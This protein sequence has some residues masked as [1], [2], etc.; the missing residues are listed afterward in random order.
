[1]NVLTGH[2]NVPLW[3]FLIRAIII[4]FALLIA[5]RIT[6][7]EQI[8]SL[9]PYDFMISITFG[10]LAAHPL[11]DPRFGVGPTVVSMA[12]L[13]FLNV[14]ISV[15]TLK[16]RGFSHVVGGRPIVLVDHGKPVK[17][18]M[19][20]AFWHL[21]DLLS[22]MRVNGVHNLEDVEFAILE[23]DGNLSLIKKPEAEPVTP[24]D[25][26]LATKYEG[27]PFLLI[28]NGKVLYEN[29]AKVGLDYTWLSHRMKDFNLSEPR[30]VYIASLD[31]QGHLF[32]ETQRAA[33][34][35]PALPG[36]PL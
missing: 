19:R 30:E 25:L 31:S 26:G 4:Y 14:L 5:V 16:S 20:E 3:G 6:G 23:T 9:T 28:E 12:T 11:T 8:S 15:L 13:V 35:K 29:L 36:Q 21:D 7:K 22:K 32:I 33:E 34:E 10:S 24:A 18:G 2:A 17:R 27:L 1:M